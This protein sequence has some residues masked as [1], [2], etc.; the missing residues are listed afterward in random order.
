VPLSKIKDV[1]PA[2]TRPPLVEDENNL[3]YLFEFELIVII[4]P[5]TLVVQLALREKK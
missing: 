4:K 2:E 1:N 3:T 5:L